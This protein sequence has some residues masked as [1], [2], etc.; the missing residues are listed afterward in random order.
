VA[1]L[2][3]FNLSLPAVVQWIGSPS[4]RPSIGTTQQFSRGSNTCSATSYNNL[5]RISPRDPPPTSNTEMSQAEYKVGL[6]E[7]FEHRR[8]PGYGGKT[9]VKETRAT[10]SPLTNNRMD[11]LEN[12]RQ[13]PHGI[14]S[15]DHPRKKSCGC[16]ALIRS[17]HVEW[18]SVI[19]D[20]T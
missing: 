12:V 19:N 11:F 20:V 3:H 1:C 15:L 9:V 7:P 16:S 10:R 4:T 18:C 8:K 13:T 14:L 5:V 17:A 6:R 2:S